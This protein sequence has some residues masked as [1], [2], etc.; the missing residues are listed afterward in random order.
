MSELT[1]K[2]VALRDRTEGREDRDTLA[3]AVNALTETP[4]VLCV[5]HPDNA[6]DYTVEDGEVKII[7]LDF[8][9]SFDGR[10]EELDT[11]QEWAEGARS[12]M[13]EA[14]LP[15]DH[16]IRQNVE[17]LIGEAKPDAD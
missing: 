15:E 13:D 10:P 16:P 14:K 17:S 7:D 6:N 4:V 11:W 5:R 12:Q 3:D 2:L 8:G 9:S 1:G